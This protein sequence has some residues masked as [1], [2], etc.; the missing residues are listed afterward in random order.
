MAGGG[1]EFEEIEGA[2]GVYVEDSRAGGSV[3]LYFWKF[4]QGGGSID[5]TVWRGVLSGV[6][7]DWEDPGRIPPQ[8]GP[9]AGKI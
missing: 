8:G 7:S 1:G 9:S 5:P 2:V 3:P 4:L 6:P